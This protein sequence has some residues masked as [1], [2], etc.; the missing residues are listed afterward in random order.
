LSNDNFMTELSSVSRGLGKDIVV[1]GPAPYENPSSPAYARNQF[2]AANSKNETADPTR[3]SDERP[4]FRPL[5]QIGGGVVLGYITVENSYARMR[6]HMFCECVASILQ[7]KA[8]INTLKV[9]FQRSPREEDRSSGDVGT[10][11]GDDR[12]SGYRDRL[13]CQASLAISDQSQNHCKDGDKDGCD[14]G[15]C[16]IMSLKGC[17]NVNS[18]SPRVIEHRNLISGPVF[19]VGMLVAL[20]WAVYII[21]RT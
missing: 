8:H 3:W 18:E 1:I 7:S 17:P 15:N 12:L 11:C 19:F 14:C 2:F 20:I 6:C 13:S 9:S 16:T 5:V 21:I 10:F 4:R